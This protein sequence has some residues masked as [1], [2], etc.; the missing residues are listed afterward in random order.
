MNEFGRRVLSALLADDPEIEFKIRTGIE[1]HRKGFAAIRLRRADGSP[2]SGADIAVRQLNHAFRF[3]A[4]AFM[5]GEFSSPSENSAFEELFTGI[6]NTAVLPFYWKDL[7]PEEG[8]LRFSKDSAKIYRRPPPE[9]GLEFC[10]KHHLVAKG[11]PLC[12][13]DYWPDWV[14]R[15]PRRALG[16]LERRFRELSELCAGRIVEWDVM[17]E[18]QTRDFL[19]KD[20]M[21]RFP[22]G[23]IEE[24]FRMAAFHFPDALL[25]YNDDNRWWNHQAD[26]SPLYLLVEK[27]LRGGCR[28]DGLGM[29]FHMFEHLFPELPRFFNPGVLYACFDLYAKL[30]LSLAISEISILGNDVY[31]G[32]GEGVV[33]QK[34]AAEKLYRIFF[35]HPAMNSIIWWNI[36]NDTACSPTEQ[37]FQA[38]LIERDFTPRPAYL[39]LK[40]LIRTEWHTGTRLEYREGAVN[41]FHGFYGD[42][43][44]EIRTDSGTYRRRIRLDR[45]N[46]NIHTIIL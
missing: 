27:L 30:N 7:E 9:L 5:L 26:Y 8:R 24:L 38:G 28:V 23:Y 22:R 12:W 16:R 35:S 44:L 46:C 31:F 33:F 17:N 14:D 39:A 1:S 32:K 10:A 15:N 29:Q 45:E 40:H 19:E 2:V 43:E 42:Y 34:L 3:G 36:V 21:P 6:F 4:N 25:M 20:W 11:H 41:K 13:H 37:K 18:A